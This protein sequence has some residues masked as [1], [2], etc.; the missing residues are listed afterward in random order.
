MDTDLEAQCK[1][2]PMLVANRGESACKTRCEGKSCMAWR[3][4]GLTNLDNERTGYC[5]LAGDPS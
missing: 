1:A 2:C 4:T 5:G 3:W